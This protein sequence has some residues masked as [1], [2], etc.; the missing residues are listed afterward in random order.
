MNKKPTVSE[1][2]NI[3][4]HMD[5]T[6]LHQAVSDDIDLEIEILSIFF[7]NV[8]NY[9]TELEASDIAD[10]RA[11]CHKLKGAARSIGAW[12]LAYHSELAEQSVPPA[13][14]SDARKKII[15]QLQLNL[16]AMRKEVSRQHEIFKP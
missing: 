8:P 16:V 7:D 9:I 4:T 15:E 6:H 3:E 1:Y 5:W 12:S 14:G 10:W 2:G 11:A 13:S